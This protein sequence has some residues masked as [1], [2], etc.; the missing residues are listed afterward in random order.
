VTLFLALY[1]YE[2]RAEDD[3]SFSKGEKFQI[4][5]ST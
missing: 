1:D 4:I 3:L 2:A 5:N